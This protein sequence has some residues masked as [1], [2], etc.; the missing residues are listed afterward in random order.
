MA[1]ISNVH[2]VQKKHRTATHVYSL[3]LFMPVN[4]ME[5]TVLSPGAK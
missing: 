4:F 1:D 3:G 2:R 5:T